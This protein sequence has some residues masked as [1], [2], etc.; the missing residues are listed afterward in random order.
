[1]RFRDVALRRILLPSIVGAILI[2]LFVPSVDLV[3]APQQ[4]DRGVDVDRALKN[5]PDASWYDED[6]VEF[7]PPRLDEF[8]DNP[9]RTEAEAVK[10]TVEQAAD[11]DFWPD[12]NFSGSQ[13][14]AELLSTLFYIFTTLLVIAIVALI[15]WF[16]VREFAPG[17]RRLPKLGDGDEIKID[18]KKVVDLPFEAKPEMGNDPLAA[19]RRLMAGDNY[20]AAI[21]FL[22]G[23]MLLALDQHRHIYLQ[24]G[25]TNRMYLRELT[26]AEMRRI[27][28]LA[29]L[30]F[31]DSFFG[32]HPL[33]KD[34]FMEVWQELDLFHACVR[35]GKTDVAPTAALTGAPA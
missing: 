29:I 24:K 27:L 26:G 25:K 19:V 17:L 13:Y 22:Y 2:S 15:V 9:L 14:G 28:E 6:T 1:M 20:D 16:I 10:P 32:K 12:W 5:F 31:E 23:Y 8:H 4:S 21:I 35:R 3:A 34:R 11:W 33:S 18:P 7:V 30:A